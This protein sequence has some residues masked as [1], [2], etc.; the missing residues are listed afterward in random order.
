[1]QTA[2]SALSRISTRRLL[3]ALKSYI[4]QVATNLLFEQ[5]TT[6]TRNSFLAQVTPYLE[7]VQQRQGL[8]AFS[9]D[10][11]DTLNTNAV[12][13]RQ[14]LLGKIYIQPTRAIEYIYLDFV[15]TPTGVAFPS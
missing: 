3:I 15:L 2:T 6:S 9:V 1:M 13:D 14:E 5:N 8:Y 7:S 12:I 11:S 10:M 4:T